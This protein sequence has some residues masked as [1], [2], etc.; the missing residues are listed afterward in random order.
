MHLETIKIQGHIKPHLETAAIEILEEKGEVAL[1]MSA[2]W[3]FTT[4]IKLLFDFI[5]AGL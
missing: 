4:L 2:K 3:H 1:L 5:H